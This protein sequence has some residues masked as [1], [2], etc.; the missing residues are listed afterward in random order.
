MSDRTR[1]EVIRSN[2]NLPLLAVPREEAAAALGMSAKSFDQYVRPFIRA[3]RRNG[4][5]VYRV[6][7]LE[8]WTDENAETVLKG[9]VA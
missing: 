1:D 2:P 9:A 3:I 4:V 5:L 6:A 8:R 7:D